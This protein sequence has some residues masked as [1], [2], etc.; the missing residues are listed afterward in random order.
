ME[1]GSSEPSFNDEF[2]NGFGQHDKENAS[3]INSSMNA[4]EL[5]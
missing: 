3:Q 1:A 2:D 4:H 5:I